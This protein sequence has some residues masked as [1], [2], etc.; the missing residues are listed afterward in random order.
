MHTSRSGFTLAESVVLSYTCTTPS[1][2]G[3][4]GVLVKD[5]SSY[6][7]SFSSPTTDSFNY[8]Y[9]A[10]KQKRTTELKMKQRS[11]IQEHHLTQII[12]PNSFPIKPMPIKS[13]SSRPVPLTTRRDRIGS[14]STGASSVGDESEDSTTPRHDDGTREEPYRLLAG[15]GNGK[16]CHEDPVVDH[17]KKMLLPE[18]LRKSSNNGSE[19]IRE[20]LSVATHI[21]NISSSSQ[22]KFGID[23]LLAKEEDPGSYQ[24][25]KEENDVSS[26]CK[27]SF[28]IIYFTGFVTSW[29][30]VIY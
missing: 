16:Y 13:A 18:L 20:Q 22:L 24:R 21:N 15:S 12:F 23:R 8:R 2:G 7:S 11:S 5:N 28:L 10:P 17:E 29:L 25:R 27:Y 6:P 14:T 30:Q 1:G 19:Y 3:K 9:L 26:Y 4:I